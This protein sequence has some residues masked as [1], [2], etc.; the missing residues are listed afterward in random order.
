MKET[1]GEVAGGEAF[2]GGDVG[3]GENDVVV[4]GEEGEGEQTGVGIQHTP[5]ALQ[6]FR[7][8]QSVERSGGQ[9]WCGDTRTDTRQ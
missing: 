3:G 4:E 5:A 6:L 1:G 7:V 2:L 8:G 9:A